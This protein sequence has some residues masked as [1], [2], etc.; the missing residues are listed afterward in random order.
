MFWLLDSTMAVCQFGVLPLTHWAAY[1][2]IHAQLPRFS[3][4][5]TTWYLVMLR[6]TFKLGMPQALTWFYNL[7]QHHPSKANTAKL[8]HLSHRLRY[9]TDQC[10]WLLAL[11]STD[12]LLSWP[13]SR[14]LRLDSKSQFKARKEATMTRSSLLWKFSCWQLCKL[15]S[16]LTH[17]ATSACGKSELNELTDHSLSLWRTCW[18]YWYFALTETKSNLDELQHHVYPSLK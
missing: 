17:K 5:R 2:G 1:L 10:L 13:C 6:V 3:A 4:T 18:S 11:I 12:S 14:T 16:R 9:L 7:H 15:L 8:P